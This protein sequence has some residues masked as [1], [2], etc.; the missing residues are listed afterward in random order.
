[1][2]K[3]QQKPRRAR[4]SHFDASPDDSGKD[5]PNKKAK[6]AASASAEFKPPSRSGAQTS[7]GTVASPS[8]GSM[9]ERN[10]GSRLA[11]VA[12]RKKK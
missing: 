1:M 6:T 4:A 12:G 9:V 3:T 5:Q 7:C 10:P 11:K 2:L 8:R